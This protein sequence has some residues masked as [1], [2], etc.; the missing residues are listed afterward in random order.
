[1]SSIRIRVIVLLVAAAFVV[2]PAIPNAQPPAMNALATNM[3]TE[4]IIERVLGQRR[5]SPY[6]SPVQTDL[7]IEF[8]I[9]RVI[10]SSDADLFSR[11]VEN[12]KL[13]LELIKKTGGDAY[14]NLAIS[15]AE[16][17]VAHPDLEEI[18]IRFNDNLTS[19]D[20][21]AIVK[22]T[23]RLG[24][25]GAVRTLLVES[26]KKGLGQRQDLIQSLVAAKPM[27]ADLLRS[28]ARV[29][30]SLRSSDQ[31]KITNRAA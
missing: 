7:P 10:Y 19:Q 6:V 20:V 1:M 14:V 23:V 26:M 8:L 30:K 15:R 22:A 28:R 31:G 9:A 2:A 29:M 17:K 27:S 3:A 16:A 21:V 4:S 25:A 24:E 18:E 5:F 12:A 11:E 13:I